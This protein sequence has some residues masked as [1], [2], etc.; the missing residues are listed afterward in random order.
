[1]D[2]DSFKERI[3]TIKCSVAQVEAKIIG[4]FIG[5]VATLEDIN[6]MS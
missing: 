6:R 3:N 1:M 5:P 4:E 2:Y